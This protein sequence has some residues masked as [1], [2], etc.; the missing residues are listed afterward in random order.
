MFSAESLYGFLTDFLCI[1]IFMSEWEIILAAGHTF[2]YFYVLHKM[3]NLDVKNWEK[4]P[5]DYH[6]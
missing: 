5:W 6:N 2:L 3:K 1:S 4:Q